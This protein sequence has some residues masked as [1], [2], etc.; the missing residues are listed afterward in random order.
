MNPTKI[1]RQKFIEKLQQKS[2]HHNLNRQNINKDNHKD[3]DKDKDKDKEHD[4]I[5]KKYELSDEILARLPDIHQYNTNTNNNCKN[6]VYKIKDI[7]NDDKI[8]N[9]TSD[10]LVHICIYKIFCQEKTEPFILYLLNKN[11]NNI[12]YFPHFIASNN[13]LKLAEKYINDIFNEWKIVPKFKGYVDNNDIYLFYE[14]DYNYTIE[15]LTYKDVWWWTSIFE[16]INIKTVLNFNIHQTVYKILKK[17]PLLL[18]LFDLDN[19]II[20]RPIIGYF[21]GYYTYISFI[22]AFGLRKVSPEAYLGPYYYLSPYNAAGRY[23]I[24]NFIRKPETID[25]KLITVDDYGRYKI[26]G[27]VRFIVFTNKMKY[28]LNRD[29][30][31]DDDSDISVD[32]AKKVPFIKSTMKIRD[33]ASKWADNYNSV[34]V[35][36]IKIK[37]EKYDDRTLKIE[38]AVR[39]FN[40]QIPIS[41]HYVN[42]NQFG[43]IVDPIKLRVLP[44]NYK[45]YN[46]I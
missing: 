8:L 2:I 1:N 27:I 19:K 45:D 20:N 29:T 33:V 41:Y 38:F 4:N 16:I 12:L 17:N 13:I 24:W 3:K 23:A 36:S 5:S 34:Y 46:I 15:K 21:G 44:Y 37:S 40:Q 25:D 28:L 14:I 42:T 11:T 10:K 6:Y 32:L 39:D 9:F 26:G 30:D 7:I 35:G 31:P 43:K 22:A 18:S